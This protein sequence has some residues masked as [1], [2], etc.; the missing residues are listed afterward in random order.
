MKRYLIRKEIEKLLDS[1]ISHYK[2]SQ[3][4]NVISKTISKLRSGKRKI[5]NITL[6]TAEKLY[7]YQMQLDD[8]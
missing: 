8:K 7:N 4:T 5:G 1:D 3:V 6:D 2:I